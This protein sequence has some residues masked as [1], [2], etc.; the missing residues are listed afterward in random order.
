MFY[1]VQIF[2]I[3]IQV[4]AK[5]SILLL[6]LR[7]FPRPWFKMAVKILIA[8]M[9]SH[10]FAFAVV[11]IFQCVP[12][13]SIWDRTIEGR[14][15]DLKA[16]GYTGAVFSIVEDLLILVLPISELNTLSFGI[17]KRVSL[18]LMFSIGSL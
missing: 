6:Y 10:G 16:I 8:F 13:S 5:I 2:Y 15:L 11:I 7:V 1:A 3:M 18:M 17:R 4:F 9:A 12:I 14:C